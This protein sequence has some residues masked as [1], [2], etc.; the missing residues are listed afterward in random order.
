[1]TIETKYSIGDTCFLFR[2]NKVTIGEIIGLQVRVGNYR[3]DKKLDEGN[4]YFLKCNGYDLDAAESNL[5]PTKEALLQ[6]L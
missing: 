5:F 4:F 2:N 3:R 1:M 6:S